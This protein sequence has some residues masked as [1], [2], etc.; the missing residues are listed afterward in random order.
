MKNQLQDDLSSVVFTLCEDLATPVSLS[1]SILLRYGEYD[2]IAMKQVKP[3]DYNCPHKFWADSSAVN[4]LRKSPE[5]PTSFNKKK[6][7]LDN[8]WIAERSC[9]RSNLRLSRFLNTP[10][11]GD[12]ADLPERLVCRARKFIRDVLGV[13][14]PIYSVDGKFGPGATFGDK[15][16]LTTIPDKMSSQPTLTGDCI[17]FLFHWTET[18][19]AQACI[20]S[21]R[22][23]VF[24]K[25]N[26][27]TT[28]PKDSTKDRG[29]AIE[30]SLNLFYQLGFGRL[31][32][33]RLL[34]VGIDLRYGQ[35]THGRVV[36]EAS[37]RGHLATID[38]SNASDT[39][40]ESLVKLLLPH[41]WHENL[42]SLRSPFSLVE[43]K[44][45]KLEKFSSMGNGY[46]FELETL[47]FLSLCF[48]TIEESGDLAIP[49]HNLYVYGDDIICPT[50]HYEN[51]LETL[52]FFGMTPN[53]RKT[54]GTGY[55]RE[56]CGE[57]YFHG[58]RVRPHH[59]E[60]VLDEPQKLISLANG[61]RRLAITDS[62][63]SYRN[64]CTRRAWFRVLDLIPSAIR[65]CRGPKE[66]G[67]LVI[68]DGTDRWQYRW[69]NGIRYFKVYRPARFARVGWD[70]FKPEVVLAS[71]LYGVSDGAKRDPLKGFLDSGG[72]TPRDAV[73]GYKVGW[74]PF[75]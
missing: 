64:D 72:V 6:A 34:A 57:D 45:V 60:D 58:V 69:R 21:S 8:F 1:V 29:I 42:F 15:G 53:K 47:I 26:R 73:L 33:R 22:K 49:G 75:S 3:S 25:G 30:P 36:R 70:H 61:L 23:P 7:A 14:P 50:E 35:D 46:T 56:S 38:L 74:V 71:A 43:N 65:S 10:L 40:S 9:F 24:C 13:C 41:D 68:H 63:H 31:I 54:F 51:V 20:E 39:I 28:V 48:A 67:D 5:L 27:F 19:W 37:I 17:P 32:R 55:F 62:G 52:I 44:W 59:Q 66:L 18:K 4:I 2:Q 11:Y 16:K 12:S